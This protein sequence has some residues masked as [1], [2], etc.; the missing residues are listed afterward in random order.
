MNLVKLLKIGRS[1]NGGKTLFGKYKM[2]QQTLPRFAS[3]VRPS[4]SAPALESLLEKAK[5]AASLEVVKTIPQAQPE[6]K[7]PALIISV[8]DKTQKIP[9]GKV[10]RRMEEPVLKKEK[11]TLLSR[12]ENK[13]SG[14][15]KKL[16]PIR[17]RRKSGSTPIQTEW[18]LGGVTVARNDLSEADLEVVA[19]KQTRKPQLIELSKIKT[20]GSQWIKK[21][22]RLFKADSPFATSSNEKSF[23]AESKVESP[24]LAGKI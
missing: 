5:M 15:K 12:I 3:T 16:S 21:T 1:L 24:E 22:T 2:A 6:A 9:A 10:L 4:G 11:I 19:P 20:S 13:F 8:L 7:G 14:L 18:A 17:S 23:E